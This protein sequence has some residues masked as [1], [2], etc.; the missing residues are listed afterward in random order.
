M[1]FPIYRKA[2]LLFLTLL[3]TM[4]VSAVPADFSVTHYTNENGL[5]Q[6]CIRGIESDKDGFLW[7][8]TESGLVRFDGQR[9]RLYDRE[10]FPVLQSNRISDLAPDNNGAL[11][12]GDEFGNN[13]DFDRQGTPQHLSLATRRKRT[14]LPGYFFWTRED[15]VYY[16]GKDKNSWAMQAPG[17]RYGIEPGRHGKYNNHFY[18]RDK[19]NILW[20]IDTGRNITRVRIKGLLPDPGAATTNF[21]VTGLY[22][23]GKTL[24]LHTGRGIYRLSGGNDKELNA[25]WVLETN[26]ENI[27]F[28]R[29]YPEWN[30]QVIGTQT[31]GFYVFRRKQFST[32]KHS[33]GFGNYYPQAPLGDSGVLTDKGPV[34]PS[35]SRFDYPFR[36]FVIFRSLLSDSRGRYWISEG[37]YGHCSIVQLDPQLQV[38]KHYPSVSTAN[39]IRETPDGR[40]WL[41]A[42]T[43]RSFGY[44]DQDSV[45]WL[46]FLWQAPQ[47]ILTFLPIDNDTFWIGG[48]HILAK[49]NVK[50]GQQRHYKS[51]E[52]YTIE[53]MYLDRQQVLWI[54]TTGNGFFA[55]KH[56]R[57]IKLPLDK[58]RGLKDVHS[59]IEDKNGFLWMSTNNGLFC[60][61]KEELDHFIEGKTADVYYQ[62]FYKESGFNTN[63][64]NGSCT[65]SA[66]VLGNGKFS[67]PSLNGLV[68]FYPDSVTK[69]L[70]VNKIVI[71]KL[72]VDGKQQLLTGNTISIAPSF[73]YLEVQ[74]ASP[75]F[76]HP[77]NQLLEYRLSGLD[78]AWHPLKEDN[79]VVFNNLAYG[80]YTLQFRKRAGFGHNNFMVTNILLSVKPFFYQ[81]LYF[82]LALLLFIALLIFLVIKIRYAFLLKRNKELEQ[83]VA[84]R[85]TH[86]DNANRLKEKM[87][88]MV[89]HD[90]QSP[91]HFL[92]YLSKENREAV[93]DRQHEKASQVSGQIESTSKKLYAFV[94]EFSLWARV[95]DSTLNLTKT[96]FPVS[97]LME[98]LRLFFQDILQFRGNAMEYNLK[99]DYELHTNMDLLKAVL[100]NLIDNANKHTRDGIIRI[101]CSAVQDP[102]CLITISD[103]GGGISAEEL[104]KINT[105]IRN[106]RKSATT[107]PPGGQLGYQFIIDF[108][109]RLDVDINITSEKGKGTT[110][111]IS[112]IPVHTHK[113][114]PAYPK[115]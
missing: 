32:L 76:G 104:E 83:E 88:M 68:Q 46:P 51:L 58:N 13:Y 47:T 55:I 22:Q 65:P 49:L 64:F 9:F 74:V 18:Y 20:Q 97:D 106:A 110:V 3:I 10:H 81:T 12:F 96:T 34:Y 86:L 21:R 105:L 89:G 79:T 67:F 2:I 57:T 7:I 111:T 85:T 70:P 52:K 4:A 69:V 53:T 25:T 82:R 15:S 44:V 78:S 77:A 23:H 98:D 92:N 63:E 100:R 101:D 31:D 73:K 115:P 99:G 56:N 1:L 11:A 8:A 62:C 5:P 29:N 50:T 39:C 84:L 19:Q 114:A 48:I 38:V 91:L 42:Y 37:S 80:R 36:N 33:N 109:I 41:C 72:L 66:I 45:R 113:I 26:V 59:F 108:A 54:G 94:D 14:S 6:N 90:L 35:S 71:D 43:G 95:Q 17:L 93:A 16:W 30:L 103:N 107:V 75:Y 40:I 102:T 28:Y 24:Y 60:C 112:G 61:K 27:R 87:L